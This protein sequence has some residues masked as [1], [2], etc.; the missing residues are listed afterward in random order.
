MQYAQKVPAHGDISGICPPFCVTVRRID[1]EC[2][3]QNT[4]DFVIYDLRLAIYDFSALICVNLRLLI[5]SLR[6]LCPF[7]IYSLF[8]KTKPIQSRSEMS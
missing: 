3:K 8:E 4:G 6:P 2:K 7:V 1:N 5:I